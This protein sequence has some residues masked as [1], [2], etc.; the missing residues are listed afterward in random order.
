MALKISILVGNPKPMSRTRGIAERFVEVLIGNDPHECGTTDLAE[1][2]NR[3]FPMPAEHLAA[4]HQTLAGSNLLVVAS[5]TYKATYTGLLK[6]VLDQ[7]RPNAL[8]GVVAIPLMTGASAAHAMAVEFHL[9]PLLRELGATV[10]FSGA[11]F[12]VNEDT[13]KSVRAAVAKLRSQ[14]ELVRSLEFT[15]G[16]NVGSVIDGE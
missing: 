15:G 11:Y 3:V 8:Q 16:K 14:L 4:L 10:P 1:Q 9:A 12:I 7:L 5:P 6:I 13:E 2:S